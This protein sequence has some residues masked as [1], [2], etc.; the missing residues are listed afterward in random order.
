M[1][2][3]LSCLWMLALSNPDHID[4]AMW[5][6]RTRFSVFLWLLSLL[7]VPL[8]LARLDMYFQ[9]AS[10]I[11]PPTDITDQRLGSCLHFGLGFY[12]R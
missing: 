8:L 11:L 6:L 1:W 2:Q 5:C 12:K 4:E 3:L 10:A 9:T 7:V